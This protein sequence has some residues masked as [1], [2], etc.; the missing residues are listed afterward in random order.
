MKNVLRNR[1]RNST[2]SAED[3]LGLGRQEDYLIQTESLLV[4]GSGPEEGKGQ[5]SLEECKRKETQPLEA[6]NPKEGINIGGE[7]QR[8]L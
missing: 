6:G 1:E 2:G 4:G 3:E 7:R 8:V 5:L